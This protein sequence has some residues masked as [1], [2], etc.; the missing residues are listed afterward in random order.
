M[1]SSVNVFVGPNANP[2]NANNG[3]NPMIIG[4]A[5]S[6][7]TSSVRDI[8]TIQSGILLSDVNEGFDYGKLENAKKLILGSPVLNYTIN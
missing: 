2:D 7:L 8:A 3:F 6:Q 5:N 1:S 4:Q